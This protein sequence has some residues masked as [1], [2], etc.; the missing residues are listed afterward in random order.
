[1]SSTDPLDPI[2]IFQSFEK[3]TLELEEK[4]IKGRSE[5]ERRAFARSCGIDDLTYSRI[6]AYILHTWKLATSDGQL[7]IE[8]RDN[9]RAKYE[10]AYARFIEFADD[11]FVDGKLEDARRA[12]ESARKT[13]DSLGKLDGLDAPIELHVTGSGQQTNPAMNRITNAA[14]TDVVALVEKMKALAGK[15]PTPIEPR[16]KRKLP[17]GV[18][19][20][21]DPNDDN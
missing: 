1:M 21:D 18:I 10:F 15:T 16:S 2:V 7:Q 9:L 8:R 13:L 12:M 17:P 3:F 11:A 5:N 20:D 19:D 4:M 14:R 6:R